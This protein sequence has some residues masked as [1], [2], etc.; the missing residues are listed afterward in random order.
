MGQ[1]ESIPERFKPDP[2][3]DQFGRI[4]NFYYDEHNILH[5][6]RNPHPRRA[7]WQKKELIGRGF[8]YFR[9]IRYFPLEDQ[10]PNLILT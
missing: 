6:L 2:I 9:Q 5:L 7:Y 1:F 3:Y 10:R 4:T 8:H